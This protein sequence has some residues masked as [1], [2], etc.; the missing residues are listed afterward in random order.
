MNRISISPQQLILPAIKI[1]A[2]RWPLLTAGD[3]TSGNFNAMTVG[4]GGLGVMWNKP[5]AMVV[6]RPSRYTY[7][8]MEEH[9]TFTLSVL[10]ESHR[11]AL[12]ICGETSGR[13]VDKIKLAGLTP[14][15]SLVVGAPGFDE[16]ELIIECR[17]M[18]TAPFESHRFLDPQI[19][20]H[21]P[22][23]DLHLMT[24]G[25]VVAIRGTSDYVAS[26]SAAEVQ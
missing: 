26:A 2:H 16:A 23:G 10:P 17:K 20:K 15:P 22:D 24:F 6:V 14:V 1:W 21:Y 3:F 11:Q 7:E 9:D 5:I 12:T 19:I 13:D 25:E 18:Y 8:F 4:W